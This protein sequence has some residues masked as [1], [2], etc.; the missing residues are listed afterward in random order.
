MLFYRV[1]D[2]DEVMLVSGGRKLASGAPFRIV[3]GHGKFVGPFRKAR[4]LPLV[5]QEAEVQEPCTTGQGIDVIVRAVIAFKVGSDDSSIVNA[6][7][8]FLTDWEST[9]SL[10]GKI[11]AGHL[12]SVVGGMTVEEIITQRQKLATEVL[13]ASKQEMA[14]MG[15][16]VDSFQIQGIDD[17]NSG[18]IDAMS[19]PQRAAVAQRAKVAQ[20]QANQAA[21]EAEQE[22][23][24]KQLEYQ[25]ATQI[26]MQDND[27]AVAQAEQQTLAK[28]ATYA[29]ET[30]KV[31]AEA[32]RQVQVARATAKAQIDRANG[33]ASQAGP[34]AQAKANLEVTDAQAQLAAKQ[35][36]L[37]AKQ[38]EIE[39]V[40]PAQAEA[41]KTRVAAQAQAD[42]QT[43]L[44][45]AAASNNRISLDQKLLEIAPSLVE[46]AAGALNGANV[47]VVNGTEGVSELLT[48]VATQGFA[49]LDALR[50]S[51]GGQPS[52]NG[53]QGELARRP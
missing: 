29:Q 7:Q 21:A 52:A 3:T 46:A 14:N 25:R 45:Q 16:V 30:A 9:P 26:A 53:R 28:K 1:P 12:R 44:A 15:L 35:S 34:L 37:R 10:V 20:A 50:K 48:G 42:A 23:Q 8:R 47:T 2:P 24:R 27:A 11:F 33:E 43:T 32:D 41:E 13:D 22:S 38:L 36:E 6:G 19:A 40:R 5:M 4:F 49:L 39:V 51:M 18:Y 31:Q 17:R